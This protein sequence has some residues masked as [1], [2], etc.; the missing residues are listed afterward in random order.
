MATTHKYKTHEIE[1]SA[2]DNGGFIDA[3]A[4]FLAGTIGR[5]SIWGRFS[6]LQEAEEAILEEAKR[7]LDKCGR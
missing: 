5:V 6:T 2:E 4:W 1:V 7:V 3:S